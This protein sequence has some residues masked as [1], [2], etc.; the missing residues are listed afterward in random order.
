MQFDYFIGV[1]VSKV[2]LDFAVAK[3]NQILFH[4]QVSNDQ[5]GITASADR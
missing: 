5:K 1:D 4:Q 2:T 3:T